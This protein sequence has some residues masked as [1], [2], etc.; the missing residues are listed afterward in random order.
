MVELRWFAV[1]KAIQSLFLKIFGWRVSI[2]NFVIFSLFI[3]DKI[4]L[5]RIYGLSGLPWWT[6]MKIWSQSVHYQWR[7]GPGIP[8]CTHAGFRNKTDFSLWMSHLFV[9]ISRW[10]IFL[11][12]SRIDNPKKKSFRKT[13]ILDLTEIKKKFPSLKKEKIMNDEEEKEKF[14]LSESSISHLVEPEDI[15]LSTESPRLR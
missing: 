15:I 12:L 5:K 7:F 1:V 14:I 9:I 4:P 3:F 8:T 11:S 13:R 6:L 10:I 2:K